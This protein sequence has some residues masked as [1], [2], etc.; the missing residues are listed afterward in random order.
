MEVSIKVAN[1]LVMNPKEE[2]RFLCLDAFNVNNFCQF[3]SGGAR[4]S[5]HGK[6]VSF[7][8]IKACWLYATVA[9]S[10]EMMSSKKW[11]L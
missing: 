7:S 1:D 9:Q 2:K 8:L 10:Q 11:T 3:V 5:I 6:L 4:I